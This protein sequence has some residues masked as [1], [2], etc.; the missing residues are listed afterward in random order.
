MVVICPYDLVCLHQM[1]TNQRPVCAL[2]V[3]SRVSLAVDDDAAAVCLMMTGLSR[4]DR[5]SVVRSVKLLNWTQADEFS[6][7]GDD[8]IHCMS[9]TIA[10]ALT[11]LAKLPDLTDQTSPVPQ[12]GTCLSCKIGQPVTFLS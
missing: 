6:T 11:R 1:P 7:H 8:N 5:D 4:S 10:A 9:L 2:C 12:P 3:Q